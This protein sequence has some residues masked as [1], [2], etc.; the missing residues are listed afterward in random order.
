MSKT[1]KVVFA[2]QTNVGKSSIAN[3]L[4]RGDLPETYP[5]IGASF[6]RKKINV[7]GGVISLDIWDTAGQE[8][9]QAISAVYFR[10]CTYCVL[11]FDLTN[12]ES[13]KSIDRWKQLCEAANRTTH[14]PVYILVGNKLDCDI[15]NVPKELIE[16]YCKEKKFAYYNE[17]S[18]YTGEGIDKLCRNLVDHVSNNIEIEITPNLISGESLNNNDYSCYC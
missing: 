5:T 17:T 4:V 15:R 11:V 1:V 14:H 16:A 10:N 13:F 12:L 9:F 3:R 7:D 8:R 2:G 6:M 18:A